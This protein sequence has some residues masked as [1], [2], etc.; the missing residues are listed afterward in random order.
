MLF[1]SAFTQADII[2]D[3]TAVPAGNFVNIGEY[4]VSAGEEIILGFGQQSG[5]ENAQGRLFG[6]LQNS[7]PT[8]IKGVLRLVVMTNQDIP[9]AT[10]FEGRTEALNSSA[11]DRTKQIPFPQMSVGAG[12]D[13]KIVLQFKADS[14]ST[15]SLANTTI[16][17]DIT[18]NLVK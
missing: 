9:L 5:Q 17:M 15:I 11:T 4:K 12:Q 18:R 16:L 1:R 13:K 10:L 3:S 6:K 2:K 8:E 14:A 7:T